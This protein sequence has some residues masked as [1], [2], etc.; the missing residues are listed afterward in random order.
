M[1]TDADWDSVTVIRKRADRGHTARSTAEINAASRMG[2][3]STEKRTAGGHNKPSNPEYQHLAKI[4]ASEDVIAPPK[5]SLSVAQ[6]IMKARQA[7]EW[8]QKELAQ[9]INEKPTIIGEYESGKGIPNQQVLGKLERV[10]GV[11]LRGKNIGEP[12][13][14]KSKE[15]K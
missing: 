14:P 6:A 2:A 3:L 5:V 4:D 13:A 9:K 15:K 12:L 7:K 11:K 1:S 8:T 10:L